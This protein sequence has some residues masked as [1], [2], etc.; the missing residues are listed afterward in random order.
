VNAL[1]AGGVPHF[2]RLYEGEGH[3]FRKSE[4]IADYLEQTERFLQQHCL[5]AP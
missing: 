1:K 2:Y 5:F 3:G 4:N